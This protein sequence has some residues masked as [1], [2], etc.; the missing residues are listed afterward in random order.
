MAREA[1]RSAAAQSARR[2]PPRAERGRTSTA[3]LDEPFWE[4]PTACVLRDG[5]GRTILSVDQRKT[6][7]CPSYEAAKFASLTTRIPLRRDS[8]PKSCR[9][10]VPR[11]RSTTP[12]RRRPVATR[13]RHA[14]TR[15]RPRFHDRVRA[16]RRFSRL[17]ARGM[18]GRCELEPELVRRGGERRNDVDGRSRRAAG[19]T[20]RR[21]ARR[22]PRMGRRRP[23]HDPSRR[24]PNLG[25]RRCRRHSPD[26]FGLLIFE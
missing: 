23:P 22:T 15:R 19:G 3:Q 24:L 8:L 10:R 12:A 18:L 16:H 17:D 11:R 1:G 26:Q 7:R 5:V 4:P 6:T 9:R 20:G 13:P 25:R 2:L 21:T 14:A